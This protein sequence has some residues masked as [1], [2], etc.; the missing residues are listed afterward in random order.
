MKQVET[1]R[2]WL[3][4]VMLLVD[5]GVPARKTHIIRGNKKTE[6][7]KGNNKERS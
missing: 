2:S 5:T 1:Y 3:V 4:L 7:H 6:N